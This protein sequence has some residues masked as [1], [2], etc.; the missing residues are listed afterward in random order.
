MRFIG[1]SDF[2]VEF[3]IIL[4]IGSKIVVYHKG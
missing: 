1:S 3:F 2:E 4:S